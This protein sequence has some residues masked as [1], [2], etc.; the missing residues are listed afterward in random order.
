MKSVTFSK[1]SGAAT[2]GFESCEF[3]FQVAFF[4]L[5][6]A[7]YFVGYYVWMEEN[8]L[9]NSLALHIRLEF[10][11]VVV[12]IAGVK[13]VQLCVVQFRPCCQVWRLGPLDLTH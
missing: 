11:R 12:T 9:K 4:N 5:N 13:Y 7:L 6:T 1:R 8:N 10:S 3:W 2:K